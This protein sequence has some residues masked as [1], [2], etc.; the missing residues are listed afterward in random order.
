M[1][2]NRK[3]VLS[4]V[5]GAGF[6]IAYSIVLGI[7]VYI[8]GPLIGDT[9]SLNKSILAGGMLVSFP[10]SLLQTGLLI[11]F[12]LDFF[13]FFFYIALGIPGEQHI[14]QAMLQISAYSNIVICG[15]IFGIIWY[16]AG[17]L[18]GMKPFI[19]KGI[20]VS[21]FVFNGVHVLITL[22]GEDVLL[23][24]VYFLYGPVLAIF[25]LGGAIA[26]YIYG[27]REYP[28]RIMPQ[29]VETEKYI[30]INLRKFLWPLVICFAIIFIIMAVVLVMWFF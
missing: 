20:L 17:K 9:S 11:Y 14:P 24:F 29:K 2:I 18:S 15:A 1:R 12:L 21:K 10:F 13:T 25:L 6:F 7:I 27:K 19:L 4:A 26:G 30:E 28:P 8:I 3:L 16:L 5:Y 22:G 23:F